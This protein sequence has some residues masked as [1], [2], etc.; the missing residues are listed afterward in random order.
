[1]ILLGASGGV[2]GGGIPVSPPRLLFQNRLNADSLKTLPEQDF[3]SVRLVH[4][5]FN[6]PYRKA[7]TTE[8]H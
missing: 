8:F 2:S 3:C 6:H 4:H 1:M 5:Q 7:I